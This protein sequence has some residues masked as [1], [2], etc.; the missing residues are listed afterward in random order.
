MK[1]ANMGR[2]RT[3]GQAKSAASA[4]V[5]PADDL[6][7]FTVRIPAEDRHKLRIRAAIEGRTVNDVITDAVTDYISGPLPGG[8]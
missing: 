1:N 4:F 5:H 8:Q 6:V 3:A 7:K 2:R